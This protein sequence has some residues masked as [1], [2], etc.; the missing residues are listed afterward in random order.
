MH[1]PQSSLGA[2]CPMVLASEHSLA[3]VFYTEPAEPGWDGTSA[4]MVSLD[5]PSERAAVV[6]FERPSAHVFGPPGDE[7]FEGHRL[8]AIGLVPY[9][10]FEVTNSKWI[11]DLERQNAV[12]PRHDKKRY[13]E[14][15]RHFILTFH[16]ST[17]EC[18]AQGYTVE[19]TSLSVREAGRACLSGFDA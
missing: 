14:G 15:K 12:H 6:R 7:V 13:L 5:S 2:P 3:V 1:F 16:D 11:L 10:A 17:F 18:V 19:I 4:R 8:A 9:A